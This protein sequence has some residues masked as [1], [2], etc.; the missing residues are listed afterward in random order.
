MLILLIYNGNVPV[1]VIA[2]SEVRN[3]IIADVA[4]QIQ[5]M[6]LWNILPTLLLQHCIIHYIPY[7]VIRV[8]FIDPTLL[9]KKI[10]H[11][12]DAL[13]CQMNIIVS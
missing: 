12:H 9:Q 13:S 8:N 3:G 5:P 7:K 2:D 6:S 10:I 1:H 11:G 4:S